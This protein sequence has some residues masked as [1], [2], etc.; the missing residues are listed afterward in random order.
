MD[1]IDRKKPLYHGPLIVH[2][3]MTVSSGLFKRTKLLERRTHCRPPNSFLQTTR[4]RD[5]EMF[6]PYKQKLNFPYLNYTL[7]G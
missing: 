7:D 5:I 1:R 6:A 3:A 4:I 2:Q